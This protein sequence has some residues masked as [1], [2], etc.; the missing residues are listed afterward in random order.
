MNKNL[1][2]HF[3]RPLFYV[4]KMR[5]KI[6]YLTFSYLLEDNQDFLVYFSKNRDIF[7]LYCFWKSKGK[8]SRPSPDSFDESA[9]KERQK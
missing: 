3:Y 4:V 7:T 1:D 2:V 6:L 8:I 9:K 5:G